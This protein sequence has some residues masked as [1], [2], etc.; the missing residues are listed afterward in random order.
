MET[1]GITIYGSGW[2]KDAVSCEPMFGTPQ[3]TPKFGTP[4]GTPMFGT[5]QGTP[6]FGTPQG[7]PEFG[8]PQGTRHRKNRLRASSL[9]AFSASRCTLSLLS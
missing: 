8:T 9:L 6:V 3:G 1:Y 4:Q 7:T 2:R 5:P